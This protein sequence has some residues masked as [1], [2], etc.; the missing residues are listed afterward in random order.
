MKKWMTILLT[1]AICLSL[2]ACGAEDANSAETTTSSVVTTTTTSPAELYPEAQEFAG[3]VLSIYGKTFDN[4]LSIKVLGVWYYCF[5]YSSP[6][7][8]DVHHF[9]YE[10]EY[11][12]GSGV[13]Q[14]S[15]YGVDTAVYGFTDEALDYYRTDARLA[16]FQSSYTSLI[17]AKNDIEAMQKGTELDSEKL[18]QYYISNY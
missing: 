14:T 15:Y 5:D 8:E 10:L 3:Q 7:I 4:P 18:Q 11:T 1:G 12:N 9:T 16:L 2:C 17:F 13:K 6:E